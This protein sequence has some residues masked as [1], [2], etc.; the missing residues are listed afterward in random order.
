MGTAPRKGFNPAR[1]A[2]SGPENGGLTAYTIATGYATAI[3]IGDPVKLETDGTLIQ[4]TNDTAAAIG[5]FNG[6]SYKNSLGEIRYGYWPAAQAGTEIVAL[7][8]DL[9]QASYHVVADGPIPLAKQGDIFAMNLTAASSATGRSQMTVDSIPTIVGD[10]DISAMTD[11]GEDVAGLDDGDAFTIETTD[12][13]NTPT[14]ITIA[15]LDTPA[16]L[17]AKLNAVAGIVA[18]IAAGTGFLTIKTDDGYLLT[19][20]N[21]VGTPITDLFAVSTHT[22]AGTKVVAAAA[23]MVKVLSVPDRDNKVLEVVL[24]DHGLRDDGASV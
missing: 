20:T 14:T 12:P 23:G 6:C 9:P 21:S 8:R 7:V 13:A 17:L 19:T 10:V 15:H 1:T 18:T 5:V 16:I 3:G 2:G 24:D 4:A 22:A 11:L